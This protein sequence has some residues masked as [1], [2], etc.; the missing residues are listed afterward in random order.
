MSIRA[1]LRGVLAGGVAAAVFALLVALAVY[2]TPVSDPVLRVVL[3][4]GTL[5]ASTAAGWFAAR[6]QDSGQALHGAL[7]GLTFAVLG[8]LLA[9]GGTLN[10]SPL[11]LELL[12]GTVMGLVGALMAATA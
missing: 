2:N 9:S 10:T 3:W 5:L 11:W 7:A 4:A 1:V 6:G 8:N 12:L